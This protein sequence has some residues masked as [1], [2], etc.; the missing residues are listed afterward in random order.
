MIAHI[1]P[2]SGAS[3]DMLL[4]ALN[5]VATELGHELPFEKLGSSLDCR[6][7]FKR[8]TRGGLACT[9][10]EVH[11]GDQHLGIDGLR[12][13]IQG[14]VVSDA[15]RARASDG[16]ELLI[17]AEKKVHGTDH[18]HLH[19]LG[20]ADTAADLLGFALAVEELGIT[21][22]SSN[23]LPVTSGVQQTTHGLMPLPVPAAAELLVGARVRGVSGTMEL[24][25]PTAMAILNGVRFAPMP[26][27]TVEA[28]GTGC[29]RAELQEPNICR[30][31]IGSRAMDQDVVVLLET[32]IDDLSSEILS[33]CA[34]QL[35]AAGALD[36]WITPIV[37]KKSR[38][39]FCLSVL[40]APG[41]EPNLAE[42]IF[43]ETSTL[44][45]RRTEHSRWVLPRSVIEVD[46]PQGRV[47]VKIGHHHGRAVTI[48]PEFED[49]ARVAT[50][51][52]V[53]LSVVMELAA[54]LAR[55]ATA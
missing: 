45:I 20:Q 8:A 46:L 12:K 43:R 49:C 37:M 48:S 50:E 39:A 53:A 25:T 33:H 5:A 40:T 17:A 21:E 4:A 38:P 10:C 18:V 14:A 47:K 22:L 6:F 23:P 44:G 30:V 24:V 27:M 16:L 9:L 15:V 32:N 31:F 28:V 35:L 1:D 54:R 34:S 52:G 55:E 19:E 11:G 26:S 29:G 42:I 41:A 3:G 36:A 13:A 2:V 51:S 7:E